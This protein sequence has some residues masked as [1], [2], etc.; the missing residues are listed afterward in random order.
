MVNLGG[1]T[2]MSGILMPV[3]NDTGNTTACADVV[4][5]PASGNTPITIS[6]STATDGAVIFYR[7][8]TNQDPPTNP[9]HNGDNAVS[10]TVRIGSNSG[11][12]TI[13]GGTPGS[14]RG[15]A[16]VAYKAGLVD[17]GITYGSYDVPESGL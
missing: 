1:G 3:E 2:D 7:V 16:C 4:I 8:S 14:I 9:V 5:S 10:P 17:S 11:A 6:V 12:V 15:L 13:S